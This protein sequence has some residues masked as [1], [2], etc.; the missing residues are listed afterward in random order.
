MDTVIPVTNDTG[1]LILQVDNGGDL[2]DCKCSKSL[3]PGER[4]DPQV[5]KAS[6]ACSRD[7]NRGVSAC[8]VRSLPPAF[9]PTAQP[10]ES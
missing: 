6:Q 3:S 5:R 1:N 2:S 10:F 8:P 7:H 9:V 4:T